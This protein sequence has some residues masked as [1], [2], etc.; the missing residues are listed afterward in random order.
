VPDKY[1]PKMNIGDTF[2]YTSQISNHSFTLRFDSINYMNG[3]EYL[4]GW[5]NATIYYEALEYHLSKNGNH[6][7]HIFVNFENDFSIVIGKIFE[8][9]NLT[10]K[11]PIDSINYFGINYYNVYMLNGLR[12]DDSLK[13]A[14]YSLN[15]GILGFNCEADT[16]IL[17]R[18]DIKP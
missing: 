14:F 3:I 8:S 13:S 9:Q 4:G 16:F 15:D 17:T 18:G 5:S 2:N 6:Y 11:S 10:A 1:K 7:C 12:Q